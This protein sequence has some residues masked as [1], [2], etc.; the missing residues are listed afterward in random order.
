MRRFSFAA[1]AM[2]SISAAPASAQNDEVQRD[3]KSAQG[4]VTRFGVYINVKPD[5]TSGPLPQIRLITP[6]AHGVVRI[7][8]GNIKLTNFKQCVATQVPAFAAFYLPT[9]S[10]TGPDEFVLETSTSEGQKQ[11]QHFRVTVS[12][13]PNGEQKI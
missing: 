3:F 1:A 9:G 13:K 4:E 8:R 2:L 5:C 6:P 11:V 7:K 10:F 12:A